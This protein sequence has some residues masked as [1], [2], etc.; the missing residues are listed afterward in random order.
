MGEKQAK[1]TVKRKISTRVIVW[2]RLGKIKQGRWRLEN[3][4]RCIRIIA[5]SWTCWIS[6]EWWRRGRVRLVETVVLPSTTRSFRIIPQES[7]FHARRTFYRQFNS[8]IT[9]ILTRSYAEKKG[10]LKSRT[11]LINFRCITTGRILIWEKVAC[12]PHKSWIPPPPC[13]LT[14]AVPVRN[15]TQLVSKPQNLRR[16]HNAT[17]KP[18]P[19]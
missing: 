1:D 18:K 11:A 3:S 13:I 9:S 10:V 7:S 2:R 8:Q 17:K 4:R 5:V 14:N 15:Q 12:N 6:G 16:P 19:P